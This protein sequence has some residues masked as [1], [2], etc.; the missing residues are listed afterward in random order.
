M[1]SFYDCFFL[2]NDDSNEIWLHIL[3]PFF[4]SGFCLWPFFGFLFWS[5]FRSCSESTRML[6]KCGPIFKLHTQS[7]PRKKIQA[8]PLTFTLYFSLAYT[9]CLFSIFQE[10]ESLYNVHGFEIVWMVGQ[11]KILLMKWKK[12]SFRMKTLRFG[13]IS[14]NY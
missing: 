8:T 3:C 11:T 6:H 13:G 4:F 1:C 9:T 2:K 12:K 7:V 5:H 14:T 10:V